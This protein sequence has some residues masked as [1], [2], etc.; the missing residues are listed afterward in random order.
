MQK[1]LNVRLTGTAPL[2]MHNGQLADPLNE[3][4]KALKQVTSKR[5]KTDADHE[6]MAHLE[7]LGS[8][9]VNGD[10]EPIIP[11]RMLEAVIIEGAKKSKN[12]PQA[13]AGVFVMKHAVLDYDG[14]HDAEGLWE[15]PEFRL[16][17]GVRVQRARVMRTRPKFDEWAA[18]VEITYNDDVANDTD[19]V[20]WLEK[21]GEVVGLGDW[22][23]RYGRFTVEAM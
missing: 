17:A 1:T 11:D 13:K 15:K 21:A 23:P 4:T 16:T 6:K 20:E 14:P 5:K 7:F 3:H 9:Y 22:R 19:I 2:V 18:D 10:G 12:G 8:L